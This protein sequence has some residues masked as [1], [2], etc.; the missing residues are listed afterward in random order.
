MLSSE[1]RTCLS[2]KSNCPGI[3]SVVWRLTYKTSHGGNRF[4]K[5]S[6]MRSLTILGIGLCCGRG[7]LSTW[8]RSNLNILGYICFRGYFELFVFRQRHVLCGKLR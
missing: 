3:L 6:I 2:R 5:I 1:A 8:P 4:H 7:I